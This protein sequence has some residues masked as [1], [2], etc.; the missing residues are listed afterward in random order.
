ML[1][2]THIC[3]SVTTALVVHSVVKVGNLDIPE[4]DLYKLVSGCIFG[5]TLPDVDTKRSWASQV[6]PM[7]DDVLRDVGALKHRGITHKL[8]PMF[9][10]IWFSN[11]YFQNFILFSFSLG[12]L[13]HMISDWFT[14]KFKLVIKKYDK[15]IYNILWVLNTLIIF[16]LLF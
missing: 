16:Y 13:S 7:I 10:L 9:P 3:F 11:M 2:R 4:Y 6:I 14:D 12:Y 1:S 5:A 8:F 15:K